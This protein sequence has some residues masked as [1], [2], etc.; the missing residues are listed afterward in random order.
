NSETPPRR[1]S[2]LS[3]L[4][5]GLLG[6]LVVL[7]AGAILIATD[8]IDTGDQKTVVREAPL[9]QPQQ[10]S[11]KGDTDARS[12]QE[13]YRDAGRGVVFIE[14]RGVSGESQFGFPQEQ[15]GTATGSGF[16]IDREG[17]IVTNDHVVAGANDVTVRFT[18]GGKDVKAEVK[19]RDPSTDLALLKVDPDDAKLVPIPIGDSDAVKVGDP[20]VAIGNPFGLSRTVTTGI[21]SAKQRKIGAS[22]GFAITGAIQ[23]DA[24]INPG[25]SGGPLL[26][27]QGRVIGVNSQIATGG[28]S[29]SVGIGF[30]VPASTI[31]RVV[32]DLKKSGA[33]ERPFIG[34]TTT[35]LTEQLADDLN[36]P[37]KRGALIVRVEDD[38]PA[39]KAGLRAGTTETTEGLRIGGDLVVE[40]DGREI[41]NPDDVL[42]A[43]EDNEVGDS[44]EIE[45]FRNGDRKTAKLKL[46]D[47]PKGGIQS[48]GSDERQPE[49]PEQDQQPLIP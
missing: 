30:A 6:G 10:A 2:S 49:R 45:Y 22:N 19:G 46:A 36:L 43:L 37:A 34:I 42:R 33:V 27:A 48:G 7:V 4:F 3:S 21:V 16:V 25:N 12:V 32:P 31:K 23:T 18:E 35:A 40:V 8:V 44:I 47:R 9:A 26:D 5:A 14:A 17:Y 15:Q 20:V 11:G 24:S 1:R 38:S 39:D 28:G 41:R 13:I 29:G